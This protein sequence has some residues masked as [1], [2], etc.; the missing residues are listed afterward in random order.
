[1]TLALVRPEILC[2]WKGPSLLVVNPSGACGPHETLSGYFFREARHLR[3]WR[4]EINATSPWLCE[5]A[6]PAPSVLHFTYTH[7]EVTRYGGGGSG[8]SGD[9]APR[10]EY[11]LPQRALAL[12]LTFSV[13]FNGVEATLILQNCAREPLEFELACALDADFADIQEAQA[14][15]RQQE[16]PIIVEPAGDRVTWRYRHTNLPFSTTVRLP[17]AFTF[18]ADAGRAAARLRLS[19]AETAALSLELRAS[20]GSPAWTPA[21]LEKREAHD[22]SWRRRF[23]QTVAP[24]NR[25]FEAVVRSSVR[26]IAS[27]PLFE[28]S[29]DEWLTLQAGVPLYPALFGRDAITAGWQAGYIDCGAALDAALTRL[30]R[31]QS[32]R[33]DDWRDEEPGRIPYQVRVGRLAR[34]GV[35]PYSAYYA[36]FAS[37]LIFVIALANLSSGSRRPNRSQ[38]RSGTAWRHSPTQYAMG[39]S[40]PDELLRCSGERAACR[41][42]PQRD[43]VELSG[44]L[45]V[46]AGDSPGTVRRERHADAPIAHREVGM[47]VGRLGRKS[48]RVDEHQRDGPAVGLVDAAN[49]LVLVTPAWQRDEPGRDVRIRIRR[50]FRCHVYNSIR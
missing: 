4:L 43:L 29:E 26:D 41:R 3:T 16:A 48:E 40:L 35:N 36:D 47:V 30:G 38:P 37:P 45:E 50:F 5:A 39:R 27:F 13:G 21:E 46:L 10:D 32:R 2:A 28:G 11:G 17:P 19:P 24:G 34:L 8:Q 33:V 22:A 12:R 14:G 18:D 23:T 31:L 9:D 49:C 25:V 44:E 42:A 15:R 6:A 7:P 1:M 20:D